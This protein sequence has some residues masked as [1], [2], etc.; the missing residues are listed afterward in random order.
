MVKRELL[1]RCM[2]CP[3]CHRILRNAT[4]VSECLHTC[5]YSSAAPPH[6]GSSSSNLSYRRFV[7]F[8]STAA[9][10]WRVADPPEAP[11]SAAAGGWSSPHFVIRGCCA[12]IGDWVSRLGWRSCV[13]GI[14]DRFLPCY[15]VLQCGFWAPEAMLHESCASRD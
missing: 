3:L 10:I 5:K 12:A 11:D 14:L 1:A 15:A 8:L 6:V 2:T 4:T 13:I 7:A 9:T